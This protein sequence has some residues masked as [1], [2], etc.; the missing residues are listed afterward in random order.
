M[1]RAVVTGK[2]CRWISGTS[3]TLVLLGAG[4][5]VADAHVLAQ[6]SVTTWH[7]DNARTGANTSEL[8]LTPSNVNKTTFGKLY[9]K[10]VD[11]IVVAQPL[12]LH[13]V[14]IPGQ[15]IHNVVY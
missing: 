3:L 2:M 4:L 10:P 9:T 7:Y 1:K 8:L 12:Y 6:V 13:G 5:F 14:N 11:G 15:G